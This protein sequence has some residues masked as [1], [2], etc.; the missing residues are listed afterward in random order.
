MKRQVIFIHGGVSF[1]SKEDFYEWL[2]TTD[3]DPYKIRNQ[4]SDS[5]GLELGQN[6]EYLKLAM[7]SKYGADY[8]AWKIWFERHFNFAYNENPILIGHS[9]GGTFLLKYLSENGFPKHISQLHLV[10]PA[11][12]EGD[13]SDLEKLDTFNFDIEKIKTISNLCDK[14]YLYHSKDDKTVT[15]ENSELVK[16]NLPNVNFIVFEDRGH[17]RQEKFPELVKNILSK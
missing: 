14:I 9:L 15:F 10:A 12:L 16:Q 7:P 3:I 11:V 17:L 4:W 13:N 5:L 8:E 1:K 2:K 6:Y